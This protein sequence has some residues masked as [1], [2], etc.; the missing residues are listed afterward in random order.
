M[1]DL[2]VVG[3]QLGNLYRLYRIPGLA[4]RPGQNT[5]NTLLLTG[6][7]LLHATL[8]PIGTAIQ[9]LFSAGYEPPTRP[10]PFY[11]L[12]STGPR[13]F[14]VGSQGDM[15]RYEVDWNLQKA[16]SLYVVAGITDHSAPPEF[17][18]KPGTHPGFTTA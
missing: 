3:E 14:C 15:K 11:R 16:Q 7:V 6:V 5:Q 13:L 4:I 8:R 1:L 2:Y 10:P 18:C 12:R 9:A 17:S